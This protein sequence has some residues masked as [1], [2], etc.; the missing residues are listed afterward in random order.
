MSFL[1]DLFAT[2]Q[3][4][5]SELDQEDDSSKLMAYVDIESA[6]DQGATNDATRRGLEGLVVRFEVMH[7]QAGVSIVLFVDVV[8]TLLLDGSLNQLASLHQGKFE[9]HYTPPCSVP[10]TE[11]G[12]QCEDHPRIA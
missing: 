11:K 12:A 7:I 3:G 10:F 5:K 4:A 2:I 6:E 8:R 9:S 1:K